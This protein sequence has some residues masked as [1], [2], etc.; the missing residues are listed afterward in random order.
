MNYPNLFFVLIFSASIL[1][2][3]KKDNKSTA[4]KP[5]IDFKILTDKAIRKGELKIY[6]IINLSSTKNNDHLI[7]AEAIKE[8][9][10][11]IRNNIEG[12]GIYSFNRWNTLYFANKSDKPGL[13]FFGDIAQT[14]NQTFIARES[15]EIPAKRIT[16]VEVVYFDGPNDNQIGLSSINPLF[17]CPPV[18]LRHLLHNKTYL[19]TN[20][21]REALPLI[22]F[23]IRHELET[24]EMD[25]N[26]YE[27]EENL[28]KRIHQ[29]HLGEL[30]D[31]LHLFSPIAADKQSTGC[32]VTYRDTILI[33][34]FF[35]QA[36]LFQKEWPYIS[37]S[38]YLNQL[39]G[40]NPTEMHGFTPFIDT[41]TSEKHIQNLW[42]KDLVL[43]K[44]NAYRGNL[45][46][47]PFYLVWF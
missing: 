18:P 22:D 26:L 10:F 32:L 39:M 25:L 14:A 15:R 2:S 4:Q 20:W 42:L 8:P 40:Y 31:F 45:D 34:Y 44:D 16:D 46:G 47:V 23:P 35:A 21:L 33:S 38:I 24:H 6:P 12:N 13:L 11:N 43:P 5:N 9:G 1:A 37:T 28:S 19:T 27:V 7:F 3:C 41:E 29:E 17:P 36:N 30:E